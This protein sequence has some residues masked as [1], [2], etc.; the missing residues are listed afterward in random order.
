MSPTTSGRSG[1]PDH[2]SY[3]APHQC[4][5]CAEDLHVTQLGCDSCGT[6]LSGHFEH[7]DFCALEQSELDVLRVF[8][9]SRGN[10]KEL[11]RHLGVSYPTARARFDDLLAKLGLKPTSP[12]GPAGPAGAAGPAEPEPQDEQTRLNT[13]QALATGELDVA[14]ARKL[15]GT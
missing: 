14:A 3:R 7:C 13:L 15:L 6:G 2:P 8:L 1:S 11:E 4:P 5:V 12:A 9:A 10:M